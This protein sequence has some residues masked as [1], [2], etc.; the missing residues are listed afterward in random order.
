MSVDLRKEIKFGAEARKELMRGIDTLANAVVST[1]GPNGRNVLID[2]YPG[3]PQSTKDGVTVAKNIFVDGNIQN[4][5][6]QVIKAAAMKTADKAGDGTTT[7]TLLAREMVKAGLSHLNNGAN[8]VEIKRGIDTAIQE[9]VSLLQSNSEEISSEEQLQQ[10]ATIS[11]NN[12][13][14]VGKLIATAIDK[15]GS[16]GVVHI[17]ESKSGETYLETVEGMQFNRGYKSHF[18]VT[19]NNTMS[20]KLDD[21][22]VLIANHKFTQVKELLP[23]LEQVSATN[24]SLLIIAEDIE[25][26]ALAT[27]IVNKARGTLK[28]AAVKAPDFGDRRKLILD[29]IAAVTGG[30]VFDKDKGMK[31]DKFSWDWFGQARAATISK[32]ETTIVDGKGDEE[33]INTRIAELQTQ[34]ENSTTPF[35]TEQLQNRLAKMVGGVSIIHVGGYNETEMREKK[36]RVDDALHATKAALEEGIVPGGGAALLYARENISRGSIGSE[37]VYEA[38]GKP[39]EQILNNAGYSPASAQIIGNYELLKSDNIWNGYDLKQES[40][41]DMKEAGIVDPAKVTRTALVNAGSA[42]GTLLLTECVVVPI[43]DKKDPTPDEIHGY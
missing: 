13:V 24:K 25:N 43:P 6:V 4:L 12:D 9:V 26:E 33:A 1:L 10:V 40:V 7:S 35:E 3:L 32:E 20:C 28:V 14:E 15:V 2:Q 16:D 27:L 31:I 42:A 8:A 18:F 22:Y 37:I 30:V 36:D 17:E 11:A 23:I 41:V 39:F 34:I 38:C 21:V 5:G 29:D 19:D